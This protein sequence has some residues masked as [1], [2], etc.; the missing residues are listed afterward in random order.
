MR[1]YVVTALAVVGVLGAGA[2]R[3]TGPPSAQAALAL[4]TRIAPR[5]DGRGD[6][7]VLH[8]ALSARL[9]GEH[10]AAFELARK[11]RLEISPREESG[12]GSH[13]APASRSAVPEPPLAALGACAALLACAARPRACRR[14]SR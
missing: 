12:W 10:S 11:A 13:A 4:P 14:R 3:E 6:E 9:Q 1:W 8:L 7:A 2:L 5:R